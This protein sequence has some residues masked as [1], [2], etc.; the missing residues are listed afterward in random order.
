VIRGDGKEQV[1]RDLIGEPQFIDEVNPHEVVAD[2]AA[3]VDLMGEV[4]T[5]A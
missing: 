5:W 1:G 4:L 2:L 3:H